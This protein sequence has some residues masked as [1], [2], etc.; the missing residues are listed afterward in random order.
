MRESQGYDSHCNLVLGEVEE[1]IYMLDEE[2]ESD[3][4]RTMKKQSEM[5][6]V[7]GTE[8]LR[9]YQ[10]KDGALT[11]YSQETPSSSYRPSS[12]R[13]HIL[14]EQLERNRPNQSSRR[15]LPDL[16]HKA[17]HRLQLRPEDERVR[18]PRRV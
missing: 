17:E 16:I 15:A 8:E 18:E 11:S 6:F 10:A 14:A 3:E 9:E 7:R 13:G 4:V 5:L 1:T 2:E 12:D